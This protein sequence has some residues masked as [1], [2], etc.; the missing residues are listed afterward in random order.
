MIL[1]DLSKF[2]TD[3]ISKSPIVF[4][5]LSKN[6]F[7]CGPYHWSF[8][9]KAIF[10][11]VATLYYRPI[12]KQNDEWDIIKSTSP[13]SLRMILT[14]LAKAVTFYIQV[15]II[16]VGKLSSKE[17]FVRTKLVILLQQFNNSCISFQEL[18]IQFFLENLWLGQD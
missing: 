8:N 6:I 7:K 5:I 2:T 10:I 17:L 3:I 4:Q 13:N 14:L 12:E 18:L 16:K 15:S 9:L 1:K 11:L